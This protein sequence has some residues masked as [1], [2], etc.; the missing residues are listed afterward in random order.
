MSTTSLRLPMRFNVAAL[1]AD[2]TAFA[3]SEWI[4]HFNQHYYQGDWSGIALRAVPGAAVALF[5]DPNATTE[6]VDTAAMDRAPA[7]QSVLSALA[8]KTTSVR[9]LKL[10]AGSTIRRHRD[11]GLAVDDGEIRLHIPVRTHPNVEFM[12]NDERVEMGE[13]ELWFLNFNHFHS[14]HNRSD[15]DRIHLVID[16]IMNPWLNAFFAGPELLEGN[17]DARRHRS[18]PPA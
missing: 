10:M 14:V 1:Q 9:F 16:C 7:V 11:Y 5:P 6:F 2:V 15:I 12:L 17:I 3:P 4:A 18:E 13:G 8:C